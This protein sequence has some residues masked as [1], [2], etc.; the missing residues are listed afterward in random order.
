MILKKINIG[1]FG[2]I[3]PQAIKFD[4][5][6]YKIFNLPADNYEKYYNIFCKLDAI[7]VK[8]TNFK[9]LDLIKLT[10]LKIISKH[11][12]GIDNFDLKYLRNNNIKLTITKYANAIS[13]AEHSFLLLLSLTRQ[14][15]ISKK[16]ID[17]NKYKYKKKIIPKTYELFNKKIFIYGFGKIGKELAFRCKSFGMNVLI[18]DPKYNKKNLNHNYKFVTFNYGIKNADFIS[19]HTPLTHETKNIFNINTFKKMKKNLIII[20]TARGGIINE[21]DLYKAIKNKLIA[22]AGLDVLSTEPPKNN[23]KLLKLDNVI[24]TPHSAASTEESRLRM[25][26]ESLENIFSFF[27]KKTY[28]KKNLIRL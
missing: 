11:G 24:I 19:I 5:S 2:D 13:V 9:A 14:L 28:Y 8:T 20:N 18:F 7:I 23:Y 21:N 15:I 10:N 25:A 4:A 16:I 12:V 27:E 3:H 1:I 26:T 17:E 6:K 22:A